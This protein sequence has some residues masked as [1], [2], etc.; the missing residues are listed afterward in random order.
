MVSF[1]RDI[2]AGALAVRSTAVEDLTGRPAETL[3][4]VMER[5]SP[6]WAT[7]P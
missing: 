1:G 6:A 3:R 4:T 2:R 7:R 5:Y